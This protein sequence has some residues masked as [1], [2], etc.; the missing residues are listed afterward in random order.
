MPLPHQRLRMWPELPRNFERSMSTHLRVQKCGV[1]L[2]MNGSER[3][4]MQIEIK[5]SQSGKTFAM[6][7]LSEKITWLKGILL[8]KEEC[9]CGEFDADSIL[10]KVFKKMS[11]LHE[12]KILDE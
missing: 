8:E 6:L 9:D 11:D 12:E 7:S 4:E 1:A 3:F 2:R 10:S 5:L